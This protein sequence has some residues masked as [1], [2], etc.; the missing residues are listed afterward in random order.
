MG[1]ILP[2]LPAT[3]P[4]SGA[5]LF[6]LYAIGPREPPL[7]RRPSREQRTDGAAE[8]FQCLRVSH[9][10]QDFT[11][12]AR[13]KWEL[14]ARLSRND[15]RAARQLCRFV[16]LE[17]PGDLGNQGLGISVQASGHANELRHVQA[18]LAR[19]VLGHEGLRSPETSR[20]LLLCKASC[21]SRRHKRRNHTPML[22]RPE[23]FHAKLSR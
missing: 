11:A 10:R 17:R 21:L 8:S 1:R 13:G 2:P 4:T 16:L 5:A 18:P 19:L 22:A 7:T 15:A 9:D 14:P 12:R 3:R 6:V 23:G 20:E